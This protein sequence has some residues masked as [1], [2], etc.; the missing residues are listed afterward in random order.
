MSNVVPITSSML[1]PQHIDAER[2]ILGA[3]MFDE[4]A[5]APVLR[6]LEPDDFYVPAHK[7]IYEAAIR[8]HQIGKPTDYLHI[9]TWLNSEGL[10]QKAG[11]KEELEALQSGVI[12]SA[13]VEELSK[14]VK[15]KSKLRSLVKI[16][17]DISAD[18]MNASAMPGDDANKV[19]ERAQQRLSEL[20]QLGSENRI[21]R[22]D[23][24]AVETYKEI[25]AANAGED[26]VDLAVLTDFDDLDEALGGFP[27]GSLSVIGGRGGMG[28]T[29]FAVDIA[30]RKSMGGLN[31]VYFSLEMTGAQMVKKALSRIAAPHIPAKLLFRKN[32][33]NEGHWCALSEAVRKIMGVPF[34]LNDN[35]IVTP[36]MI[37][38]DLREIQAKHG[39]IGLV[40]VDY[41]QLMEPDR[42]K[43]FNGRHDELA[44]GVLMQLRAIA[45]DFNCAVV[46]LAQIS[47]GAEEGN[48]KR[49]K[50][51][52]FSDSSGFEKEA[53]VMMA[54][55][56]D[57]VYNPESVDKG[58]IEVLHIK[59]RFARDGG[60]TK[61]Y[62]ND[63][64]G[65][66]E[67]IKGANNGY[68]NY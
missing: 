54:L 31:T 34:W 62:F 24:L 64:Y 65:A 28:K 55:Y 67:N 43:N 41:V 29:T 50:K 8:L 26:A 14:L 46:G 3:I 32:A 9:F 49:P 60:V 23:E 48:D 42:G 57:E 11:G 38:S 53:A 39:D 19:I 37:R 33:L 5:S 10:L 27:F 63:E 15:E 66:F 7:L 61:L 1:P 13:G 12:T 56:R 17:S 36:S 6:I 45:K 20:R 44:R 2:V 18:A 22:L 25:E 30:L 4:N 16:A 40:V 35:P 21:Q 58:I 47:R 59:G 68:G 51:K 52:D